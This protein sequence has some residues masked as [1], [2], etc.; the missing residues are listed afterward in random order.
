MILSDETLFMTTI[1]PPSVR[2]HYFDFFIFSPH[3]VSAQ[4]L[5]L[6]VPTSPTST[7]VAV[8]HSTSFNS[9]LVMDDDWIRAACFCLL[10]TW[11]PYHRTCISARFVEMLWQWTVKRG[12]QVPSLWASQQAP[13]LSKKKFKHSSKGTVH[14]ACTANNIFICTSPSLESL[15]FK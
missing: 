15:A 2:V 11:G 3:L 6:L 12:C 4:L 5:F 7:R 14:K 1:L 10:T 8:W 9:N 13:D